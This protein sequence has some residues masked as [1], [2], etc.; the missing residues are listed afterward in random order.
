MAGDEE[1]PSPHFSH[2]QG[3]GSMTC[4]GK[5]DAEVGPIVVIP[6][7]PMPPVIPPNPVVPPNPVPPPTP[8]NPNPDWTRM[9][10]SCRDKNNKQLDAWRS[11]PEVTFEECKDLCLDI[12]DN[13]AAIFWEDNATVYKKRCKVVMKTWYVGPGVE[14][15]WGKD[16]HGQRGEAPITQA[17]GWGGKWS[18]Y[19]KP[20]GLSNNN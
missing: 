11:I 20:E 1:L 12:G 15:Q 7:N 13:C 3:W 16:I 19:V 5:P 6:P 4:Y 2:T 10:G 14:W 17:S 8:V 9:V 18:C